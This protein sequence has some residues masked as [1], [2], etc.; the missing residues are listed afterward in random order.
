[1]SLSLSKKNIFISL[2]MIFGLV[3]IIIFIYCILYFMNR[4]FELSDET[5]YLYYSNNLNTQNYNT[6]QFGIMNHLV[7]FGNPTL[8]NLR[9]AKFT[10][11]IIA[12][13]LFCISVFKYL[14]FKKYFIEPKQKIFIVTMII[15]TSFCQYD[16]TPMTLSYNSWSLILML[17][18]FSVLFFEATNFNK[19]INFITSIIVG[20][21]CFCFFLTKFPNAVI[22]SAIYGGISI[23]GIRRNTL[24]KFSGFIL[25]IGL[26]YFVFLNNY[27]DLLNIIENYRISLFE[28][29]HAESNLYLKQI[30]KILT[31]ITNSP[32][33]I[34][35][36]V[37]LLIMAYGVFY[38]IKKLA[39]TN[40]LYLKYS[41][42]VFMLLSIVPFFKG[43]G[44][45]SYNDFMFGSIIIF[46]T[47][48]FVYLFREKTD[49]KKTYSKEILYF[50]VALYITPVLLMLGTNNAFYYSISPT[51]V[52]AITASLIYILHYKINY[53]LYFPLLNIAICVFMLS[54]L[55]FGVIKH[56]YRQTSLLDKKYPLHTSKQ[57]NNIY[58]SKASFIDISVINTIIKKYNPQNKSILVFF[59]FFGFTSLSDCE[60][61]TNIPLSGREQ[62]I[63]VNEYLLSHYNSSN[64]SGLLL[65]PENAV[66]SIEFAK[67]FKK[68]NIILNEN[69]KLL[70]KYN[71][72]GSEEVIYIY[73]KI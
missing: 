60:S 23:F 50:I 36:C 35:A 12:I 40:K 51:M 1:M 39:S 42:L 55:Y 61:A 27:S 21:I 37:F 53:S 44:G 43:N 4:G 66:Q 46:N 45:I 57:I 18:C 6:T 48:L 10:Y 56:P 72:L 41:L 70:F 9:I 71:F 20:C 16:F 8:L 65:V 17:L 38:C 64:Y 67:M 54:I 52:F 63:Y 2:S 24:I 28:I 26:G 25:G 14:N 22:A 7:C 31:I 15:M 32:L 58:E 73:K 19:P 49:T 68:S 62:Y 13:I 33:K 5:Y 59:N 69:Y 47:F 34:G 11:Q 3:S 30:Y 29:K